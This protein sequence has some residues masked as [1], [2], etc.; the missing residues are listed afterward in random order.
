MYIDKISIYFDEQEVNSYIDEKKK[1]LEK[2]KAYNFSSG[3][4]PDWAYLDFEQI[5]AHES[6]HVYQV[7]TCN[8]LSEYSEAKRREA[9]VA[10]RLLKRDIDNGVKFIPSNI[11][12]RSLY[13]K[14]KND[15]ERQYFKIIKNNRDKTIGK[16][17]TR[18][19]PDSINLL[20]VVEGA[21]V[22]FQLLSQNDLRNEKVSLKGNEYTKAWDLF[23]NICDFDYED[24]DQLGYARLMFLFLCDIYLKSHNSSRFT[25]STFEDSISLVAHLITKREV[26]HEE[27]FDVNKRELLFVNSLRH[28]ERNQLN[29]DSILEFCGNL[30]KEEQFRLYL[31][32]RLYADI[33]KRIAPVGFPE[34]R[35]KLSNKNKAI[36]YLLSKKFSF[37]GTDFSIPCVLSDY[38]TMCKFTM[39]WADFSDTK[40]IDD[41]RN[42]ET[43]FEYENSLLQL[44]DD[45]EVA[46]LPIE[47]NEKVL[48]CSEHGF[49]IRNQVH[50]CKNNDSL[51]ARFISFFKNSISEIVKYE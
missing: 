45:L 44:Y 46:L 35:I 16:L 38:T 34:M 11:G 26:Y 7:L 28:V 23:S 32:V 14:P 27:Y 24:D 41:T 39:I 17:H 12:L 30:E 43:S 21:A 47:F 6:F 4:I 31:N 33:Y 50:K 15:E 42:A 5:L 18:A 29:F 1:I 2:L 36:N 19:M 10:L 37:W 3:D 13:S 8:V 48:C 9:L 51:N 40:F 49:R 25:F 20:E 22:A